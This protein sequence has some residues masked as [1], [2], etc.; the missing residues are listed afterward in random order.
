MQLRLPFRASYIRIFTPFRS[1]Q[2]FIT[3]CVRIRKGRKKLFNRCML[4]CTRYR[5]LANYQLRDKYV[6]L[7]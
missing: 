6:S 2:R 5:S 1:N 4:V 7:R 3:P